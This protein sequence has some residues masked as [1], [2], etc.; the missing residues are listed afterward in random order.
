MQPG[1]AVA[2]R[3]SLSGLDISGFFSSD[4]AKMGNSKGNFHILISVDTSS[5]DA[6]D[7]VVAFRCPIEAEDVRAQGVKPRQAS[8]VEVVA[9]SGSLNELRLTGMLL[10]SIASFSIFSNHVPAKRPWKEA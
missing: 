6:S 3:F 9:D 10:P 4:I 5:I 8:V 7:G 2:V 1:V